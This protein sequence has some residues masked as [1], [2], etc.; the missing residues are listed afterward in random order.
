MEIEPVSPGVGRIVCPECNGE[1]QSYQSLFP[2][3]L[4]VTHCIN[5]KGTGFVLVSV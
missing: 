3:E 5:C 1:P 2:P 4:G